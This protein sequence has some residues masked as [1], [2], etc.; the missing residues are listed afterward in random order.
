MGAIIRDSDG[1]HAALGG[2]LQRTNASIADLE[3]ENARL[4]QALLHQ[5]RLMAETHHRL[6][7][8]FQLLDCT[9]QMQAR[10][11]SDEAKDAI[12]KARLRMLAGARIHTHLIGSTVGGTVD[13]AIYL[14]TLCQEI[15]ASLALECTARIVACE[16]SLS[17]ATS[18]GMIL[19]ELATNTAKHARPLH[20][21]P[22]RFDVTGEVATNDFV[23]IVSDNGQGVPADFDIAGSRSLGLRIVAG[24]V[25]QLGGVLAVNGAGFSIRIPRPRLMGDDKPA[26]PRQI[27]HDSLI[28]EDYCAPHSG[29]HNGSADILAVS[30]PAGH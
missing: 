22:P 7:N 11:A 23:L 10:T 17:S 24:T 3:S 29:E 19:N 4:R 6:M 27:L 16:V 30:A 12:T 28:G 9:L 2:S 1:D 5:E 21:L 8:N 14:K 13:L 15:A 26:P 20:G 25:G 18:L